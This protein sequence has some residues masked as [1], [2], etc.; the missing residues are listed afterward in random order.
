MVRCIP[1]T[2]TTPKVENVNNKNYFINLLK[3]DSKEQPSLFKTILDI[4]MK[5]Q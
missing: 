2:T 1:I 5:F 3:F 4:W